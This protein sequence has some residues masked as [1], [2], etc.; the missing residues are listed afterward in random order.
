MHYK[1]VRRARVE[2]ANALFWQYTWAYG[3]H[4]PSQGDFWGFEEIIPGIHLLCA[5]NMKSSGWLNSSRRT[6]IRVSEI[7]LPR[8]LKIF[9]WHCV[10]SRIAPVGLILCG[11]VTPYGDINLGQHWAQ[12]MACCL[13]A[14]SHYLNQCWLNI[15]VA[16]WH[17]AEND[18]T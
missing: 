15:S 7:P 13:T 17:S 5:S 10:T 9:R 12:V 11:L 1:T 18:F 4:S 14:P 6:K 2:R 8:A 16:S 3:I